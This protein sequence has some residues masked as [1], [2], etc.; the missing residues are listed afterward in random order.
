[1]SAPSTARN[2]ISALLLSLA[3]ALFLA[4]VY[5]LYPLISAMASGLV[6]SRAGAGGGGGRGGR[7]RRRG[8]IPAGH[9]CR[10]TGILSHHLRP[11]STE[12]RAAL[13]APQRRRAKSNNGMHPTADTQLLILRP[14]CGAAGDAGR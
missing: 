1:M 11:A 8:I 3:A 7:R 2:I 10:R 6:S 12:A 5:A 14:R 9:P 13:M 4:L